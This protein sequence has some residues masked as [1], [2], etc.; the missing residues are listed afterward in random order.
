MFAVLALR[1]YRAVPDIFVLDI[2]R[3]PRHDDQCCHG[4]GTGR[5]VENDTST[6]GHSYPVTH[7]ELRAEQ[8]RLWMWRLIESLRRIFA[9]PIVQNLLPVYEK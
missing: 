4:N 2:Q 7:T 8:Q 6:S 9:H 3:K 1:E 5:T